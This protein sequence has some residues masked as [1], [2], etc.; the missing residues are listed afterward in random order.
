MTATSVEVPGDAALDAVHQCDR[1]PQPLPRF[2]HSIRIEQI[3]VIVFIIIFRRSAGGG[4][5]LNDDR[6]SRGARAKR[7]PRGTVA[8]AAAALRAS[9]G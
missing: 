3:V 8:R 9:S 6:A 1:H 4:P 2:Q 5:V 7:G